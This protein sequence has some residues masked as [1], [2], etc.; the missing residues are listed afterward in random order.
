MYVCVYVYIYIIYIYIYI[1]VHREGQIPAVVCP[2]L[3]V[4]YTVHRNPEQYVMQRLGLVLFFLVGFS[5]VLQC[6]GWALGDILKKTKF[7]ALVHL[8]CTG[9][10]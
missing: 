5:Y 3:P 6:V 4:A 8:L 9:A 2:R 10:T 1:Y 7:S